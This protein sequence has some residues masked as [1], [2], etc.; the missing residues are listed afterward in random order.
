MP[1]SINVNGRICHIAEQQKGRRKAPP[2]PRSGL[3]RR[4]ATDTR[5]DLSARLMSL[6][7]ADKGTISIAFVLEALA[8][9][10]ARGL[11]ANALL[12]RAGISPELLNAPQARV[13][14]AHYGQLWHLIAEGMD[15]EFFGMEIGRASCR[16]R[17]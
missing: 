2:P 14:S 7:T 1:K 15:D 8:G 12:T 11:D 16:E 17:V 13:S 10:R 4:V 5:T 9:V 3:A 6:P